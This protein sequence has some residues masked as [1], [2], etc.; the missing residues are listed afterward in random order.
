MAF[1]TIAE[2]ILKANKIKEL[3]IASAKKASQ[4]MMKMEAEKRDELRKIETHRN[5]LDKY[6]YEKSRRGIKDELEDRQLRANTKSTEIS[7]RY[8]PYL[9]ENDLV[10]G[11]ISNELKSNELNSWDRNENVDYNIKLENLKKLS[12]DNTF[13]PTDRNIALESSLV[14]LESDKIDLNNQQDEYNLNRKLGEA[15]LTKRLHTI[16]RFGT[17]DYQK[18][19]IF[20]L[21]RRSKQTSNIGG[22]IDN[23]QKIRDF[24]E[25][26]KENVRKELLFTMK[27]ESHRNENNLNVQKY[28]LKIKEVNDGEQALASD[29]Y[30]GVQNGL[31]DKNLPFETQMNIGRGKVFQGRLANF[32]SNEKNKEKYD[33]FKKNQEL[34]IEMMVKDRV[35]PELINIYSK[36]NDPEARDSMLSMIQETQSRLNI[37]KDKQDEL[38]KN[39]RLRY[40]GPQSMMPQ[41]KEYEIMKQLGD[42]PLIKEYV[43]IFGLPPD[44]MES[45]KY[46]DYVEK[47]NKF[48]QIRKDNPGVPSGWAY[49]A[50]VTGRNIEEY[51]NSQ[52]TK[53]GNFLELQDMQH[54]RQ[55]EERFDG[56]LNM[57][58]ASADDR[59]HMYL[60]FKNAM[61]GNT[62]ADRVLKKYEEAEEAFTRTSVIGSQFFE[63]MLP[64][65]KA[66]A[67]KPGVHPTGF[68]DLVK[69]K[70]EKNNDIQ[71]ILKDLDG[72]GK[73]AIHT[74]RNIVKEHPYLLDGIKIKDSRN[75]KYFDIDHG[76]IKR[77]FN[78]IDSWIFSG[79]DEIEAMKQIET[80]INERIAIGQTYIDAL[81]NPDNSIPTENNTWSAI[82][83]VD[84]ILANVN[85]RQKEQD[86]S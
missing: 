38:N 86:I 82:F 34:D 23:E 30:F 17:E 56:W 35:D 43:S 80:A 47:G 41:P 5:S 21:D 62:T 59:N 11:R 63:E 52:Q 37:Q 67:R 7:N 36:L 78:E 65:M 6:N 72:L 55:F 53:D 44:D 31:I 73:N 29:V 10:E 68:V 39:I 42:S 2:S 18:D 8:S 61:E 32:L 48:Q 83:G 26:G 66:F 77:I 45:L 9:K 79:G 19:E 58:L 71:A 33:N 74:M 15:E 54:A 81:K 13:S 69:N 84:Q 3:R 25:S 4:E 16:D 1:A 27:Q 28:L 64:E 14:G 60:T 85:E 76:D 50:T 46:E 12:I 49:L 40:D 70:M 24:N 57:N 75:G 22:L 20:N 51:M